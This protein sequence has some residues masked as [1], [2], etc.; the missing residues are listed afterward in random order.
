M[1]GIPVIKIRR[2]VHPT[3]LR[4]QCP[5]LQGYLDD[6][7]VSPFIA[8]CDEISHGRK[9][10]TF[11]VGSYADVNIVLDAERWLVVPTSSVLEQECSSELSG[12]SKSSRSSPH[13]EANH[14]A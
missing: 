2:R 10:G 6:I 12:S 5:N 4:N 8:S 1:Y 14:I 11:L 7:I 9:D 3:F 13:V